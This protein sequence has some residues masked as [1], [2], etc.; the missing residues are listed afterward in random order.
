MRTRLFSFIGLVVVVLCACVGCNSKQVYRETID[1]ADNT[2]L[3][4]SVVRFYVDVNDTTQSYDI[5][6]SIVNNDEYPYSN[7]YLFTDIIFPSNEYVRDTID[8]ILATPDGE[9]LGSGWSGYSNEFQYK[10][11]VKFPQI[12]RYVFVFEQAMRCT[13]SSCG[14]AG[15]QSV[16]L[17]M[18]KK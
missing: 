4:D 11:N 16:S 8:F 5:A 14:V 13:N 12:G 1:F 3:K 18:A 6:F 7:L 9:W 2:W 10:T 17:S 15:L